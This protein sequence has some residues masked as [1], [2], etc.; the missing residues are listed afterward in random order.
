MKEGDDLESLAAPAVSSG[1]GVIG[2]GSQ[3]IVADVA[4]KHD[5]PYVCI[6]AGTRN[7]FALDI[8]LDREDVIGALDAYHHGTERR[9]DLAAT[10]ASTST[11]TSPRPMD[12]G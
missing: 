10:G 6:P 4:S 5:I 2:D 11:S 8:G 1:A 7:H 3:P 12:R 9:I